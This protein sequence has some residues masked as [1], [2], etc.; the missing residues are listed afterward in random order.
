[1]DFL[2]ELLKLLEKAQQEQKDQPKPELTPEVIEAYKA[3]GF[4]ATKPP[5]DGEL[6]KWTMDLIYAWYTNP[7]P[8][9]NLPLTGL[10]VAFN[11]VTWGKLTQL[12]MVNL[13][14]MVSAVYH[15]GYNMGKYNM[16][17]PFDK[18]PQPQE[19]N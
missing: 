7:S 14:T 12:D 3:Y 17:S 10:C 6:A 13:K 8:K 15:M 2:S 5:T 1:M 4:D 11:M 16:K 18:K 9:M 19:L